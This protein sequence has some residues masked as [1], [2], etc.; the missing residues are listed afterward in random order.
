M[1]VRYFKEFHLAQAQVRY[2][3]SAAYRIRTPSICETRTSGHLVPCSRKQSTAS[4]HSLEP[5][6]FNVGI[7]RCHE[8]TCMRRTTLPFALNG[9]RGCLYAISRMTPTRHKSMGVWGRKVQSAVEKSRASVY[10]RWSRD[11]LRGWYAAFRREIICILPSFATN[12]NT[13]MLF[14]SDPS[15]EWCEQYDMQRPQR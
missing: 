10:S 6:P 9:R 8:M 4:D 11:I 1:V 3:T 15:L 12:L 5:H 14:F 13:R 7:S 2:G